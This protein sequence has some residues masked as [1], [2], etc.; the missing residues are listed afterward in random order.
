MRE[1]HPT[2]FA[3]IAD[4]RAAHPEAVI[5]LHN[6]VTE[7]T[8]VYRRKHPPPAGAILLYG[9]WLPGMLR[10]C[11]EVM[12]NCGPARCTRERNPLYA[13]CQ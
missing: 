7:F 11:G 13:P 1:W 9:R 8:R 6:I 5:E 12:K 4:C 3:P 10:R 2:Y